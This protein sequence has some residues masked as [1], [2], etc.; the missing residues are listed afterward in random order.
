MN[1]DA[2]KFVN[3]HEA[4]RILGVS[5]RTVQTYVKEG[6]LI[7]KKGGKGQNLYFIQEV[8]DLNEVRKRS[9]YEVSGTLDEASNEVV[10]ATFV[11]NDE[12]RITVDKSHYEELM[13]FHREALHTVSEMG[14]RIGQLEAEKRALQ[15][16][17]EDKR[18]WWKKI[19]GR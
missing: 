18:P 11:P 4:A 10:H 5:T 8:L 13:K 14:F 1:E 2:K 6:K 19:I 7:A 15:L 3:T 12:N 16:Q 9:E 17:L